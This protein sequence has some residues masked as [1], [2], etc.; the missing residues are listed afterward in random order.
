MR[1]VTTTRV[2]LVLCVASLVAAA[3]VAAG[4]SG[5]PPRR[6]VFLALSG[7]GQVV[8]APRGISCPRV[9]RAFFPKDSSVRLVARPAAGWRLARWGG[10]CTGTAACAFALTTS[11][12]C[13]AALCRVGAFGVRV[14]F[15]RAP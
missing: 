8:S 6:V 4:R 5:E 14:T 7:Q 2:A 11:H 12:E 13:S 3:G 10:S 1:I 15:V 9:C